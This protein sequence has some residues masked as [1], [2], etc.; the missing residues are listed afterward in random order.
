MTIF[1][2]TL[3][4]SPTPPRQ[5]TKFLK[6]DFALFRGGAITTYP[7]KLCPIF[8]VLDPGVHLY[9]LHVPGYAYVS[10]CVSVRAKTEKLRI[11]TS[12]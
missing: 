2:L 5:I 1:L 9:P 4:S 11:V 8:S 10:V 12:L 3:S 7:C 6:I